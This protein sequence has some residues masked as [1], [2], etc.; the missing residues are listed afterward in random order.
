LGESEVSITVKTRL[1][2]YRNNAL[3]PALPA[4]GETFLEIEDIR[5][6]Q[7]ISSATDELFGLSAVQAT[8]VRSESFTLPKGKISLHRDLNLYQTGSGDELLY[9]RS[10]QSLMQA[11]EKEDESR[12]WQKRVQNGAFVQNEYNLITAQMLSEESGTAASV[13]WNEEVAAILP[14]FSD[15]ASLTVEEDSVSVGIRFAL[16]ASATQRILQSSADLFPEIGAA[17]LSELK[18]GSGTLFMEKESGRISAVSFALQASV[19]CGEEAGSFDGEFSITIDQT[20]SIAV[21]DM[22]VPTPTTPG[23][24]SDHSPAC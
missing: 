9:Y 10:L 19:L 2:E 15:F 21:P 14:S 1:E 22:Q 12:F 11:P 18:D 8:V 4:E 16:N 6:P 23:M 24:Q 5:L 7:M 13:N 3:S 17:T 20:E